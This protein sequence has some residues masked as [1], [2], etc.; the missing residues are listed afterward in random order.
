MIAITQN[1][2]LFLFVG[3]FT[4]A[5][6]GV[7]LGFKLVES[8]FEAGVVGST[9]YALTVL[10]VVWQFGDPLWE[11]DPG[12]TAFI[13]GVVIAFAGLA[14]GTVVTML[15]FDPDTQ[16]ASDADNTKSSTETAQGASTDEF[17]L[18]S[19]LEDLED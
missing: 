12:I 18:P 13:D 1:M 9:V 3:T 11:P 15:T 4:V 17:S 14:I 8:S 2:A 19:G 5:V 7:L 10:G 16:S 6:V